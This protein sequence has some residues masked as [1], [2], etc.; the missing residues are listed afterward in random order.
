M[1]RPRKRDTGSL[2]GVTRADSCSVVYTVTRCWI[3]LSERPSNKAGAQN[4]QSANAYRHFGRAPPSSEIARAFFGHGS[5]CFN[6]V[7]FGERPR[8]CLQ[9]VSTAIGSLSS[10]S[11]I[12]V[13]RSHRVPL[14]ASPITVSWP[15]LSGRLRAGLPRLSRPSA[16]PKSRNGNRR[17]DP[18]RQ[19]RRLN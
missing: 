11:N 3:T 19:A 18:D 4:S 7:R 10:I 13:V 15:R 9:G 6:P 5:N 1:A 8:P 14:L 17:T 16:L 12:R 2:L